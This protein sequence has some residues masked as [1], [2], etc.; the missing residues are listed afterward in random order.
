MPL[1]GIPEATPGLYSTGLCAPLS[2]IFSITVAFM[3]FCNFSLP[4]GG[5]HKGIK[6][7]KT[8]AVSYTPFYPQDTAHDS[9]SI[10]I[11]KEIVNK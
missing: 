1:L 2:T 7:W 8:W 5:M 6:C 9:L 10:D 11:S 3:V 4:L